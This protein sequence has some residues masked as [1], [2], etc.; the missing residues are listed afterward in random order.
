MFNQIHASVVPKKAVAFLMALLTALGPSVA[1]A[2]AAPAAASTATP[3]RHLV[4]VFQENIS[5][6]H[7]F[8]KGAAAK[9]F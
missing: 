2:Y 5:F 9:K 8:G 1:P 7:Y 3:I 6:D 4:V